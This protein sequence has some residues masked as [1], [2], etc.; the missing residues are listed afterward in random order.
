[1]TI[2]VDFG[3]QTVQPGHVPPI[4]EKRQ[5]IYHFLPLLSPHY[6]VLPTQYFWQVYASDY[7]HPPLRLWSC[8]VPACTAFILFGRDVW[9][10]HAAKEID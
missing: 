4:F 7:E 10:L 9:W 5:C 3:V 1:M 2:G 6:F 8:R